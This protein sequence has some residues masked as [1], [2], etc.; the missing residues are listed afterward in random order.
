MRL[1][2]KRQEP[3]TYDRVNQKP[4]IKCSICTGEKVAG[5]QNIHTGSFEDVWL[6][7]GEEDLADFKSQYGI[8]GEIEK[9]Y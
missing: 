3:K 5:F 1:F 4:V 8:T 9:I 6:I 7:R 2:G